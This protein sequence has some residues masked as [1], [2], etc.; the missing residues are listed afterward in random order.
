M[1]VV[2]LREVTD[3]DVE[4]FCRQQSDPTARQMVALT[5]LEPATSEA[6]RAKWEGIRANSA[7]WVRTI[8]AD[9][10]VA[11]N[12]LSFIFQP[13]GNREVGFWLGREFWGRGIATIAVRQFLATVEK[14][15]PIHAGAIADNLGSLR[16]LQK[17]GFVVTGQCR[18]NAPARGED[19]DVVL[20]ELTAGG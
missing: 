2:T 7:G 19:V 1:S 11:G 5:Q 8:E 6:F 13:T 10:R 20:L 14:N 16:V 15:R 17:C 3:D 9:G 12:V 18:E 4:I